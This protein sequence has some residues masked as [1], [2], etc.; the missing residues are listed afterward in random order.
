MTADLVNAWTAGDPWGVF[1]EWD[2]YKAATNDG[3]HPYDVIGVN[4]AHG[5]YEANG[6][7]NAKFQYMTSF[8]YSTQT[9]TNVFVQ[10]GLGSG[11]LPADM[12]AWRDNDSYHK[13]YMYYPYSATATVPTSVP[14]TLVRTQ[15]QSSPYSW[16]ANGYDFM[17]SSVNGATRPY[18]WGIPTT[19]S[20]LLPVAEFMVVYDDHTLDGYSLTKI[21]MTPTSGNMAAGAT[22]VDLTN[23]TNINSLSF[24]GPAVS[25]YT[26]NLNGT[27]GIPVTSVEYNK[28]FSVY[29][30]VPPASQTYTIK[31]T[32][33]NGKT[34]VS[35]TKTMAGVF[36]IV[37]GK[38]NIVKFPINVSSDKGGVS[39]VNAGYA[40]YE[41]KWYNWDPISTDTTYVYQPTLATSYN[42]TI[43]SG[44]VAT[45]ACKNCP[46]AR[47][48]LSYL[49]AGAYWDDGHNGPGMQTHTYRGGIFHSG[50]WLKKNVPETAYTPTQLSTAVGVHYEKPW[51]TPTVDG[52]QAIRCSGDYFFLP[53]ASCNDEGLGPNQ[54]ASKW[55]Y[56]RNY[57]DA[58][59]YWSST[60]IIP[61]PPP[62]GLRSA[63][64]LGPCVFGQLQSDLLWALSVDKRVVLCVARQN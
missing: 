7:A 45:R 48:L 63:R 31:A 8:T 50:L 32:F 59:L 29:M 15:D 26:L 24:A 6:K 44:A 64:Q 2:N 58:S 5:I 36:T 19:M 1:S 22:T 28:S 33:T 43:T 49:V 61:S 52:D 35:I 56:V 39:K 25:T 13:F 53:A 18:N 41:K 30:T 62:P 40:A 10:E 14:F 4:S 34:P 42:K 16:I 17:W 38:G 55:N 47:Q 54:V 20:R 27:T 37:N 12:I 46:N 51:P 11:L 57:G 3:T 60:P 21:E 9:Y 23:V